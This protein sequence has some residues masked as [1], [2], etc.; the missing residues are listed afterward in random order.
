MSIRAFVT[1]LRELLSD[2][3]QQSRLEQIIA[4]MEGSQIHAQHVCD[5]AQLG[6][7]V[8]GDS[9][10]AINVNQST[11]QTQGGDYA[12]GGIDKRI[13]NIFFAG[14]H[15]EAII[16]ALAGAGGITDFKSLLESSR[17][18][19]ASD[20]LALLS[21]LSFSATVLR[22]AFRKMAPFHDVPELAGG[23][24]LHAIFRELM[25][26]IV[27]E[28]DPID[29]F[30]HT[31]LAE[32]DLQPAQKAVLCQW[33]GLPEQPQT[34]SEKLGLLIAIDRVPQYDHL[35]HILAWS[36]P[37]RRKLWPPVGE[38][39]GAFSV[40][41]LPQAIHHL[42]QRVYT[43][44]ARSGEDLRVELM[45]HHS[46]LVEPTHEWKVAVWFDEDDP[47]DMVEQPLYM[48]HPVVVRSVERA[49]SPKLAMVDARAR[50][51]TRW[52][53]IRDA[54]TC[55]WHRPHQIGAPQQPPLFCP[56]RAEEF[57][58]DLF[59]QLVGDD[60]LCFVETVAPPEGL[61][62]IKRVLLRIVRA[63]VPLGL[64]F[65]HNADRNVST[66]QFLEGL[67]DP[68]HLS[69]LPHRLQ[70]YWK[71]TYLARPLLFFDDPN[72]LP[73]DPDTAAFEAPNVA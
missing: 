11:R 44:I 55:S 58:G 35:Y 45:L 29:R 4:D 42:Y 68:R 2:P 1:Q 57:D 15:P 10:G 27:S 3:D 52:G 54:C 6:V 60:Y 32:P 48:R 39:M 65:A 40:F 43:D 70:Q 62:F 34:T 49:L 16:A 64:W 37:D 28:T 46:L 26:N 61:D 25:H 18:Q 56:T 24:L 73:Y 21:P 8:A 22:H 31:L 17:K 63:G 53:Q 71:Q 7:A 23:S 66:Y 20:L 33:L 13:I 69:N 12:E 47:D 51:R 59:N 19:R 41:E 30:A 38:E 50:W 67:L 14:G 36:W 5:E 72:R 9:H